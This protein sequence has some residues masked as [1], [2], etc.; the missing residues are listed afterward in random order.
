MET[1]LLK[2]VQRCQT[3]ILRQVDA[4]CKKHGLTYFALGGTTLGAVRHGG[5]IPWDDD[6]DVGMPRADYDKFLEI[7]KTELPE[8]Y[9]LQHYTTELQTPFYFLKVRRNNTRF[10]E[11]YVRDLPIHQGVFLD[12]FPFDNV[13]DEKWKAKLHYGLCRFLYQLYLG[14]SLGEVC[15]SRF[16][17]LGRYEKDHRYYIRKVLHFVLK[18]VPKLWIAGGLDR[19]CRMFNGKDT[20]R[21]SHIVRRRLTVTREMLYPIRELK[22][23]DTTIPVPNDYDA[24]LRN[25]FGDYM[26]IPKDLDAQ[27]H[28]PCLVEV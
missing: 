28:L 17:Q 22:F 10:V 19:A 5:F 21:M 12:I 26:Q 27:G 16:E 6:I 18:P 14:K 8:E 7:A 11:Y 24:Y 1:E 3:D 9:F 23:E 4:L 15:S 25:Q 20:Q 2:Q 13:P